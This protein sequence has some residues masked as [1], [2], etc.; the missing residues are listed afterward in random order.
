MFIGAMALSRE[1][2]HFQMFQA[3][4]DSI[5]PNFLPV[6]L[7]SDP[8]FSIKYFNMPNGDDLIGPLNEGKS[9]LL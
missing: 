9:P 2:A 6:I 5:Q 1:V 7:Q 8:K 4:L 3:A